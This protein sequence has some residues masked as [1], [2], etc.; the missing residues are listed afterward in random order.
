MDEDRASPPGGDEDA[1]AAVIAAREAAWNAGDAQVYGALLAADAEIISATGRPAA[2]REALL[3]LFLEQREG[4][5]AGV[6]TFTRVRRIDRP[7]P[8][9]ATVEADYRLEGGDASLRRSGRI[10][11]GMRLEGGRWLIASIRGIPDH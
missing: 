8:A 11:F 2:G 6:R 4:V 7:G 3:A 10:A 1:I 5:Y 9:L